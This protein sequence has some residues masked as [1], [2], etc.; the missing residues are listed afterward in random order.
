AIVT[1]QEIDELRFY[2]NM[3]MTDVLAQMEALYKAEK[4]PGAAELLEESK[5]VLTANYQF[6]ETVLPVM[7]SSEDA[8]FAMNQQYSNSLECMN[9]MLDKMEAINKN[10]KNE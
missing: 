6:E 9:F 1:Q 5:R 3:Q 4:N 2:Y 8:L 10:K 7:P